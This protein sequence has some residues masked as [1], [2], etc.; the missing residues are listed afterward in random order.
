MSSG[1]EGSDKFA[2]ALALFFGLPFCGFGTAMFLAG[3]GLIPRRGNMPPAFHLVFGAVLLGAGLAVLVGIFYGSRQSRRRARVKAENPCAPWMWRED[4]AQGRSD[5]KT[6]SSMLTACIL[7]LFWNAI[8]IPV[9]IFIPREQFQSHP[10]MLLV[11]IFP[12]IGAGLLINAI[13][14]TLRWLE[15][16][17][18]CFEMAGVPCVLGRELRGTIQAHFSRSPDHGIRLKLTCVNRVVKGSG[19]NQTTQEKILLRHEKVVAA[20]ELSPGP[21]GT[22]IPVSFQLPADAPQT[23]TT[24]LRNSF[25]WLLEADGD[26]P[27]V[28]YLDIFEIPVFRTKE[29]PSRAEPASSSIQDESCERPTNPTIRAGASADGGTEF[30]FPAAR[31][32]GFATGTTLFASL[33]GGFIWLMVSFKAPILFPLVF[34]GF[35]LL[36]VYI[37][38]DMWT[39][40]STVVIGSGVVS[41]RSGLLGTGSVQHIPLSEV[42]SIQAAITAQ[43]GGATGTPYYDIQLVKTDGKKVTLG[44]TLRY[45]QEANWLIAEMS[46]LIQPASQQTL[47]AGAGR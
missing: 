13:R 33:W 15:F 26:V 38:L 10:K 4:W 12:V 24:N 28:D 43:Q 32:L 45:K 20:A 6:K 39:G 3:M 41:L 31:N 7:G 46:R 47:A 37:L 42:A 30:Y 19:N 14:Q 16:G 2:V 40:T 36:L 29:T 9:V 23:D 17:K 25:F 8:S 22:M 44:K 21:T 11:L 5:S 18:T 35:E 1:M 34:G 27:G